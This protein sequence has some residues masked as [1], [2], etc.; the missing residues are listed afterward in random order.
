MADQEPPPPAPGGASEKAPTTPAPRDAAAA[1]G[2]AAGDLE[3]AA[4]WG[5]VEDAMDAEL[6]ELTTEQLRNRL[7]IAG[8]NIRALKSE[9]QTS[10][11]ACDREAKRIAENNEKLKI[12]K[13][14]PYL[15]ANVVEVRA[16]GAASWDFF[17]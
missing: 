1:A 16:R 17:L 9:I 3:S 5:G 14:L 7:R 12:Y 10:G 4:I 6:A 13:V 2:G 11:T 15:V 8:D